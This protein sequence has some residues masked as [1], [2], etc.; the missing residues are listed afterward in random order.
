MLSN[1][2]RGGWEVAR[3]SLRVRNS[4]NQADI[5]ETQM[6]NRFDSA[7]KA[8]SPITELTATKQDQEAYR[9][10]QAIP[11]G[12]V[13]LACHGQQVEPALLKTIKMNYP[14]DT[15]TGFTLEDIRGAFTL[16]KALDK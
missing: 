13:C 8:G 2:L 4:A 7:F 14:M 15:A 11:T 16:S 12:Q 1:Y 3:T 6:L 5:W 9:Y 10:M